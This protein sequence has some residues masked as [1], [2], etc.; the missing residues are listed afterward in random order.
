M[1]QH[2]IGNVHHI[3][4]AV[5]NIEEAEKQYE[6]LGYAK[7]FSKAIEDSNRNIKVNFLQ[8]YEEVFELISVLDSEKKSP[9][10][11]FMGKNSTYSMYHVAYDVENIEEAIG[12]LKSHGYAM[13][14]NISI[15]EIIDFRRE[16]YLYSRN[17]GLVELLEIKHEK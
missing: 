2:K 5:K 13:I 16:V 3:G 4:I 14:E 17:M 15:S 8:K 1:N 11:R 12:Y 6:A 10:D 9:V 7:K